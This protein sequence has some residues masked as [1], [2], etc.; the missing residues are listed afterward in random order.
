[1]STRT[2]ASTR[3]NIEIVDSLTLLH[4]RSSAILAT[5]SMAFESQQ[6]VLPHSTVQEVLGAV[7]ALLKNAQDEVRALDVC[8]LPLVHST[9][10]HLIIATSG[11]KTGA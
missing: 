5:L 3:K 7:Q 8:V 9:E 6:D 2:Q 10:R 11:L 1:M 4:S